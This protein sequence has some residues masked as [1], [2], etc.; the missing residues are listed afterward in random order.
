MGHERDSKPKIE[1]YRVS[2]PD[3]KELREAIRYHGTHVMMN[4]W[5]WIQEMAIVTAAKSFNSNWLRDNQE[6]FLKKMQDMRYINGFNDVEEYD[7]STITQLWHRVVLDIIDDFND[8]DVFDYDEHR[9]V[10]EVN[11]AKI[12]EHHV[13]LERLLYKRARGPY[14]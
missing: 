1:K 10:M 14:D 2:L 5:S 13:D 3:F 11:I 9:E 7:F 8:V 6:N 12:T 4:E